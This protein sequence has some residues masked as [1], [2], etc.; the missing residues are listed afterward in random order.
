MLFSMYKLRDKAASNKQELEQRAATVEQ[1]MRD[2]K[3]LVVTD[4]GRRLAAEIETNLSD[5]KIYLEQV[6]TASMSDKHEEVLR[7]YTEHTSKNLDSLASIASLP[8]I[9][10][11][12]MDRGSADAAADASK[13]RW[14]SI[15]L[16]AV[17]L[18]IAPFLVLAIQHTT[19][20]LRPA[21]TDW[22]M[23]PVKLPGAAAQVAS[24]SG[25]LAH[26][27][28][29]QAAS[30]EETSASA[31]EITSMTRKNAE[32][33]KVAAEMMDAV[34]QRVREGNRTLEEMVD[35][36]TEINASSDKISKIIKVIDEIAFHTNILALNAAVEAA[37]ARRAWVLP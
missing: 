20:D 33:S 35:S 1:T 15:V 9:Q 21:A 14:I 24:S 34:D 7:V 30:L 4:E 27:A 8:G 10:K 3:P 25:S 13:A 2:L 31:E 26:G 19:R 32:N 12:I 16:S 5:F 23:G 22:R 6:A 18:L 11:Q 17:G 28:S 37:R 29:E 36:M